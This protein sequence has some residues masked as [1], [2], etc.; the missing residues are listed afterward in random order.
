MRAEKDRARHSVDEGSAGPP[1]TDLA[2]AA[3]FQS[4]P[5][6][7]RALDV[8][9]FEIDRAPTFAKLQTL[10]DRAA[11]LQARW[12]PVKEVA[13][14]AGECWTAAYAKL[15]GELAKL[16]KATGTR[17]Q[18]RGGAA[19]TGRG[20][21]KT[22]QATLVPPVS[23]VPTD[24]D[25]GVGKRQ[26]AQARHLWVMGEDRK[27]LEGKLK[28]QDKA[29]TPNTV[30]AEHRREN[31]EGKKQALAAAAFSERGPFDVVVIDPP[32]DVEKI[33]RELYQNQ[34]AFDYPTMSVDQVIELWRGE[35]APKLNPDVHVFMWTTQKYLLSA[36]NL[37]GLIGLRY[38]LTMVW[39][40]LGGF[41]PLDLPQ[42]NCEFAVYARLGK[43]LFI[44]TKDFPCCFQAPRREHSRKPDA[45][46]DTIRLVTGGSRIDVFSR[47]PRDGFAQYGN[48]IS[49]F[50]QV[51][52]S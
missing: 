6:A 13:D 19:G 4:V 49:K 5:T 18:L 36:L 7:L 39:H 14:R 8:L 28:T 22:G 48:E 15:G 20:T 37:L 1:I 2:I 50:A 43:P 40:K 21:R 30:L 32:W 45:F 3:E 52:A 33:D 41:Q 25:K 46:Y 9:A 34:A 29:I 23:E 35:I 27:R 24:A 42:Y 51:V 47:E 17:G 44:D 26:A 12:R 10:A 38:V 31:K 11:R 16:P